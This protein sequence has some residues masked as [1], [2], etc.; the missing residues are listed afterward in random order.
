MAKR[1]KK[2]QAYEDFHHFLQ[3]PERLINFLSLWLNISI[4]DLIVLQHTAE[5]GKAY[6]QKKI[7]K[8]KGKEKRTLWVPKSEIKSIQRQILKYF[9]RFI[10]IHYA[11]SSFDGKSFKSN[12][13]FHS[14]FAKSIYQ[15]DLRHA[16]PSVTRKRVL[17]HLRG[18]FYHQINKFGF[19]LSDE[20]QLFL[21]QSMVDL[22][23][24][25]NAIPQGAPT[26]PYLLNIVCFKL[27]KEITVALS[28][29]AK[30]TDISM[31]YSRY[32]DDITISAEQEKAISE[33]I[34]KAIKKI[35]VECNFR[36]HKEKEY[37]IPS[38]SKA[39]SA[40][41]TGLNIHP[42]G[43]LTIADQKLDKY[44]AKLNKIK[45]ALQRGGL[46]P[47]LIGSAHGI[48]GYLKQVYGQKLPSKVREITEKTL[49]L[50][51]ASKPS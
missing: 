15:L 13:Q 32:V 9:L 34:R 38:L 10:P 7:S 4:A 40:S 51:S 42:D 17:A 44:R 3:L 18:P 43:R 19:P 22:V 30:E 25:Q 26:S 37:Y 14:G 33:K 2:K 5:N 41:V 28:E 8:G 6:R 20:E 49:A 35:I 48:I 23:V 29:L 24:Y 27:D 21:L 31:R 16:F 47:Q 45:Q 39:K 1:K 12:A 50:I 11:A 46:S 36:P